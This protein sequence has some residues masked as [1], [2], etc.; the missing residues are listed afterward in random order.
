M[1]SLFF[2]RPG[3]RYWKG[4]PM[5]D[6]ISISVG[7]KKDELA[8]ASAL[9]SLQNVLKTLASLAESKGVQAKWTIVGSSM[10][11]P[12]KET[13]E[14]PAEPSVIFVRGM[15][16]LE[17]SPRFPNGFTIGALKRAQSITRAL[18]NGV[19]F[20][21]F[22]TE[23]TNEFARV[24]KQC[25]INISSVLGPNPD[26]VVA[27]T[28]LDGTLDEIN[29][30]GKKKSFVIYDRL[31]QK[32]TECFFPDEKKDSAKAL[33]E[34]RVSVFGK[35]TFGDFGVPERI[36]VRDFKE[37]PSDSELPSIEDLNGASPCPPNENPADYVRRLR[38]GD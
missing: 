31:T 19:S 6:R 8:V 17:N 15:N 35:A 5:L 2:P 11:S 33:L 37:I 22:K 29:L 3:G 30:H 9:T 38:D 36:I 26:P 16:E 25:D 12:L 32:P 13:W 23:S 14:G 1:T 28:W 24:S 27:V 18:D 21:E 10:Q 4:V 20:F 34:K 7:G